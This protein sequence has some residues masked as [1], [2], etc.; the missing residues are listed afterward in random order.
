MN[1]KL[2]SLPFYYPM[3]N[4]MTEKLK[5]SYATTGNNNLMYR[6]DVTKGSFGEQPSR[7]KI[8]YIYKDMTLMLYYYQPMFSVHYSEKVVFLKLM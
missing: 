5:T 2:A 8:K 7:S 4:T 3:N 6:I 1:F